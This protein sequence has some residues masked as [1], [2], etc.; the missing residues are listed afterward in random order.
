MCSPYYLSVRILVSVMWVLV[1]SAAAHGQF[2][3]YATV[4]SQ[5]LLLKKKI[6]IKDKIGP[7]PLEDVLIKL[8][9]EFN[10]TFT[11]DVQAFYDRGVKDIMSTR[12]VVDATKDTELSKILEK[13]LAPIQAK[14][15]PGRGFLE[16]V[17]H[18]P[19]PKK[20]KR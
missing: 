9:D 5:E 6:T 8:S 18:S 15:L 14:C 11:I 13:I 7:L 19:P 20:E 16:I 10:I 12:V 1:A 2:N 3:P 17:P 4:E